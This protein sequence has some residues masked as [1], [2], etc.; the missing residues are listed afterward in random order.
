MAFGRDAL[1]DLFDFAVLSDEEGTTNDAHEGPA[2]ELLFLPGTKLFDRLVIRVAQQREI[3]VFLLLEQ[4]LGL[5]G[6]RA[7]AEDGHAQLVETPLCVAKLGR[8]DG[9]TGSAGFG[10]EKEEDALTGEVFERDFLAF[11][12][13]EAKGGGFGAYFEH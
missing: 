1:P 4:R 2:H 5:D 8:F 13:W 6:I 10:E 12:G 11:V 9:S 7:H 3:D